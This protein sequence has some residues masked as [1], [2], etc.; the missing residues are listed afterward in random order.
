MQEWRGPSSVRCGSNTTITVQPNN[1][2]VPGW[3]DLS[4]CTTLTSLDGSKELTL[5]EERQHAQFLDR[6]NGDNG[7][8][9]EGEW[10]YE[11]GK[12][13][14]VSIYGEKTIY[15]LL[16][17]GEAPTCMLIKGDIRAADLTASWFSFPD[18]DLEPEGD[19]PER[20]Y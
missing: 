3:K 20:N 17:L 5:S 11:G 19:Y 14:A 10:S 1:P 9:V 13:Y 2:P 8:A 4:S 18:P 12:Q 6:T 15:T 7:R 16:S